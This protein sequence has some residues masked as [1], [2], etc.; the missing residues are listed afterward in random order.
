M[1]MLMYF[2]DIQTPGLQF[3][4]K[5]KVRTQGYSPSTPNAKIS[6]NRSRKTSPHFFRTPSEL[7]VIE[8]VTCTLSKI[9]IAID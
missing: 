1:V 7:K 8:C 6:I 9:A 3:E 4:R 5:D 2:Q